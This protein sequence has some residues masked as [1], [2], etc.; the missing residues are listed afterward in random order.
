M[1]IMDVLSTRPKKAPAR[2]VERQQTTGRHAQGGG[3]SSLPQQRPRSVISHTRLFSEGEDGGPVASAESSSSEVAGEAG[4]AGAAGAV[5]E[6]EKP[7]T[8]AEMAQ[9]AKM[10]E[11]ERLRAKEKFITV[12][13]GALLRF[14]G[15]LDTWSKLLM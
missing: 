15:S 1:V 13:T 12:Q 6:E 9:K 8:E 10:A 2:C 5:V 4:E 14:A 11:I 3:R 7:L